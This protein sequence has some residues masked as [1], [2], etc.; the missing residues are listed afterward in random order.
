MNRV[1][2]S[3]KDFPS[4]PLS[5]LNVFRRI[6]SSVN[7]GA[8]GFTN[9]VKIITGTY[10]VQQ[11]DKVLILKNTGGCT[12]TLDDPKACK[13]KI[14]TLKVANA[15]GHTVTL[16]PPSGNIDGAASLATTTH[17]DAIR[18]ASDSTDYWLV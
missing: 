11:E 3:A 6:V 4:V 9:N 17:Y 12:I 14:F 13:N 18:F 1:S 7:L 10:T 15:S 8:D 5:V 2:V 16:S